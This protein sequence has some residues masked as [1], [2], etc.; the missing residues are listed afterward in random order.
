MMLV[1]KENGMLVYQQRERLVKQTEAAR[2]SKKFVGTMSQR[3][4][5]KVRGILYA[6]AEA[7]KLQTRNR[8]GLI[9]ITLTLSSEQKHDDR[10]IK[11]VL[12]N[13]FLT[14]L[15]ENHNVEHYYWVAET[16]ENGNIHFHVL[17]DVYIDKQKLSSIWNRIQA[18]LGYTEEG[19]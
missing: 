18:K 5:S 14:E 16:Q 10:T 8:R 15:R 11:K 4:K 3:T 12:L 13:H 19:K 1:I 6:W 17:I 7:R 9:A 2:K